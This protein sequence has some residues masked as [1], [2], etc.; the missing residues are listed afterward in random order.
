MINLEK[1][2]L[3]D[4]ESTCWKNFAKQPTGQHSEI[5]EIGFAILDL[6]K[7]ELEKHDTIL[8]K[9]VN[10]KVSKFCTKLTSL[11]QEEVDGGILFQDACRKLRTEYFSP[12]YTWGSYGYFDKLQ[13]KKQCDET[14]TPFPLGATHYNLKSIFALLHGWK[15]EVDY[16]DDAAKKMGIKFEGRKHRGKDD[17]KNLANMVINL[18]GKIRK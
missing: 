11:T 8:V 7:L 1:M 3:I 5:I 15:S 16:L 10:S 17:V 13:L 2:F 12:E 6:K 18:M 9:P 4:T 14:E